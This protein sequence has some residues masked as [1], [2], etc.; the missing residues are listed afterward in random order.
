MSLH[1]ELER[2]YYPQLN[3]Y[4]PYLLSMETCSIIMMIYK[5][6]GKYQLYSSHRFFA[7]PKHLSQ[8]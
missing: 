6:I 1:M 8:F 2:S 7:S 3:I 4:S 5:K